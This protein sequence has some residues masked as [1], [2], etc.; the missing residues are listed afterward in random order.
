LRLA[1]TMTLRIGSTSR[2]TMSSRPVWAPLITRLAATLPLAIRSKTK[3]A[4]LLGSAVR[5]SL[6]TGSTA[7]VWG[8][9]SRVRVP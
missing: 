5:I 1:A 8:R 4:R 6:L 3:I 7:T 9:T 2:P